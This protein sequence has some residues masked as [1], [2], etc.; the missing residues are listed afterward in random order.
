MLADPPI[1]STCADM[2]KLKWM[3]S[4]VLML[5]MCPLHKMKVVNCSWVTD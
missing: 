2:M 5:V 1:W 3:K 4:K